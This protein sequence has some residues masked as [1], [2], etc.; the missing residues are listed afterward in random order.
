MAGTL[1]LT[2]FDENGGAVRRTH[3]Q[4]DFSAAPPGRSIIALHKAQTSLLQVVQRGVFGRIACLLGGADL[5]LD[6]RR[7]H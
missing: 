4:I 2:H 3:D 7:N 5:G 1:A 6:L